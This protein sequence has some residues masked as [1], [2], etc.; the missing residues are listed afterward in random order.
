MIQATQ[1][2]ADVSLAEIEQVL[3]PRLAS[4]GRIAAGEDGRLRVGSYY[5]DTT[6]PPLDRALTNALAGLDGNQRRLGEIGGNVAATGSP[7]SLALLY[8]YLARFASQGLLT[9]H[10]LDDAGE[11][12]AWI[13]CT[14][15]D[16]RFAPRPFP[17]AATCIV[18]RFCTMHREDDALK[19]E[20]PFGHA[21][22]RVRDPGLVGLIGYLAS[23]RSAGEIGERAQA[24]G[25]ALPVAAGFLALC[26]AARLVEFDDAPPESDDLRLWSA[27]DL[28]FHVSSRYGH[29][30]GHFGGNYRH[31]DEMEPAPDV[32][33][34]P[35]T[36]RI[37]LPV[38]VL[39]ELVHND[40][41]LQAVIENRHSVH[42]H[43]E[44]PI[45]LDDLGE[46]LYR[47][48]RV[49]WRG[50][51]EVESPVD[52]KQGAM[53]I[54]SRPF[55]GGGRGYE[56]ELYLTIERCEGL[57][58]GLYHY[59]PAGHQ[60]SL[61]RPADD[62]TERLIAFAGVASPGVRPQVLITMAA[63]F[64]RMR[65][66]YDRLAYSATLKHVGVV[67]HQMYL[68]AT[69][70][71]LAPCAQ[72]G[73][74]IDRFAAASGNPFEVEGS[75]GEFILGSRADGPRVNR[76]TMLYPVDIEAGS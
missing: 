39:D 8:A 6:L 64:R 44:D 74:D 25:I 41:P 27:V 11:E 60:L 21:V 57:A 47:T 65:W 51:L 7:A 26:R 28:M 40:P 71:R 13:Q 22:V 63:R 46:F 61:V 29:G 48:A 20:S 23:H 10:L 12:L 53:A 76:P 35:G 69:A 9:H 16:Y 32:R 50:T 75:V 56:L 67:M 54:S 2:I 17:A 30:E 14:G 3:A 58:R 42:L 68:V 72:G 70:M 52:G 38:P 73:G 55:P 66:K 33:P 49:R 5:G 34:L 45:T 24:F 19:L 15:D 31:I 1:S 37:R 36:E 43:G 18:S 4:I 62:L 59:D